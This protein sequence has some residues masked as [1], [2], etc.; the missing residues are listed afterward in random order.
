MSRPKLDP[1]LAGGC[2]RDSRFHLGVL[3]HTRL[4]MR[5]PRVRAIAPSLLLFTMLSFCTACGCEIKGIE[6]STLPRARVGQ[7]YAV[8]FSCSEAGASWS[9]VDGALPPGLT[10]S[11]GGAIGGT[12]TA[13]GAYGIRV[14]AATSCRTSGAQMLARDYTI[15]VDP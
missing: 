7:S 11:A 13:A 12:P 5:R 1:P 10:F 6:P 8:T 15:D 3:W 2:V 9:L 4:T 14:M